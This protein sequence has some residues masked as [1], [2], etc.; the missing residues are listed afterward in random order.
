MCDN[1]SEVNPQYAPYRP[2]CT[3]AVLHVGKGMRFAHP[4]DAVNAS[5]DGDVILIHG[6]TYGMHGSPYN[7]SKTSALVKK[8]LAVIGVG[9]VTIEGDGNVNKGMFTLEGDESTAVYFEN[10]TF[11]GASNT[12]MNGAA[13]RFN[14]PDLTVV[15]STFRNNEDGILGGPT[16]AGSTVTVLDSK[17]IDNGHGSGRAH[18]IYINRGERLIV[19]GNTF[20]GTHI[21]NHVKSLTSGETIVRNNTIGAKGETASRAVD[22]TNGGDV[23]IE[24]NKIVQSANSDSRWIVRYDTSRTDAAVPGK[25]T[26]RNNEIV[27]HYEGRTELFSTALHLRYKINLAIEGNK[28]T[29]GDGSWVWSNAPYTSA[30]NTLNGES[31]AEGEVDPNWAYT[32]DEIDYPQYVLDAIGHEVPLPSPVHTWKTGVHR[33]GGWGDGTLT[34]TDK[35]DVLEAHQKG[36]KTMKGGAGDD[37]YLEFG[38]SKIVEQPAEGFDWVVQTQGGNGYRL[39]ANVEGIVR[40]TDQAMSGG[41]RLGS[42]DQVVIMGFGQGGEVKGEGGDDTV[43]MPK[44]GHDFDGG[45]G[46]DTLI[47]PCAEAEAAFS[48]G[49]WYD[50]VSCGGENIA[51]YR[52][53]ERLIFSNKTLMVQP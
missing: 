52:N 7:D 37:V 45:P 53:V 8:N 41:I 6:G 26:I 1:L 42:G 4:K 18:A 23:V 36:T 31:V 40:Y 34:G 19:E 44:L 32:A 38:S 21:G 22:V 11:Q 27:D 46:T 30:G 2:S 35:R 12:S 39:S 13:I 5:R 15:G 14:H 47:L 49:G 16:G 50:K 20:T 3:G 25:V 43:Y 17:F 28:I 51:G 33:V 9:N 29:N 10:M 24:G 48:D